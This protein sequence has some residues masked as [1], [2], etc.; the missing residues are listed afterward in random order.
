MELKLR[1]ISSRFS[2]KWGWNFGGEST[3]FVNRPLLL[4]KVPKQMEQGAENS[5]EAA[6]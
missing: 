5:Q 1:P 6:F 4:A 2:F 3:A